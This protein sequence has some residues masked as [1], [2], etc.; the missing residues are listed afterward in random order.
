[1]S[2]RMF[3]LRICPRNV[4]VGNGQMFYYVNN[5]Q[6]I[7]PTASKEYRFV[8]LI[9]FTSDKIILLS[10]RE[11]RRSMRNIVYERKFVRIR[12]NISIYS[13]ALVTSILRKRITLEMT[14]LNN[15]I[16]CCRNNIREITHIYD[17]AVT[18]TVTVEKEKNNPDSV[19]NLM[20]FL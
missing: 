6:S 14:K 19:T 20:N 10:K 13:Y 16:L 8:T 2:V 3:D 4:T 15:F 9:L 17:L 5:I 11:T 7:T 1:M 18:P 12:L